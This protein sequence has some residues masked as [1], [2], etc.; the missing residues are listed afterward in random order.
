MSFVCGCRIVGASQIYE[1]GDLFEIVPARHSSVARASSECREVSSIVLIVNEY[2][3]FEE[4]SV[5]LRRVVAVIAI[6]RSVA[7]QS[8]TSNEAQQSQCAQ[9]E[10]IAIQGVVRGWEGKRIDK[11]TNKEGTTEQKSKSATRSE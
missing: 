6:G 11:V 7:W 10:G 5:L 4:A 2:S 8:G 9:I 3:E 1:V